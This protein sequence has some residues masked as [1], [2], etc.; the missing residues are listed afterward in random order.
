MKKYRKFIMY[1]THISL[2]GKRLIQSLWAFE[3][4]CRANQEWQWRNTLF[5]IV[6][7]NNNMYT[8]IELTRIDR[9][10]VY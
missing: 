1:L 4:Y 5:I 9:S 7:W 2:A 8:S 6:K 10:H 3:I